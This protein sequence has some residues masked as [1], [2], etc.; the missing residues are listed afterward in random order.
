MRQ[1]LTHISSSVATL[2]RP[3]GLAA[4]PDPVPFIVYRSDW[5]AS[6]EWHRGDWQLR[7]PRLRLLLSRKATMAQTAALNCPKAILRSA[8]NNAAFPACP[9]KDSAGLLT[10]QPIDEPRQLFFGDVGPTEVEANWLPLDDA[11][12]SLGYNSLT[13]TQVNFCPK[14]LVAAPVTEGKRTSCRYL[15]SLV[16]GT[17]PQA[18]GGFWEKQSTWRIH[19]P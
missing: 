4:A 19:L 12:E 9:W 10:W 8:A 18:A 7:W 14:S 3:A 5:P 6:P 13:P 11:T 16:R 15:M 17:S 2:S 1:H